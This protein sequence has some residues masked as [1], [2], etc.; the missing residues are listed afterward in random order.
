MRDSWSWRPPGN[1]LCPRRATPSTPQSGWP[2]CPRPPRGCA[3]WARP[4]ASSVMR[5]D[6]RRGAQLIEIAPRWLPIEHLL[7]LARIADSAAEHAL[8]PRQPGRSCTP[9]AIRRVAA[10]AAV[11]YRTMGRGRRC[12]ARGGCPLVR[13]TLADRRDGIYAT[14]AR[15]P[16]AGRNWYINSVGQTMVVLDPPPQFL[17]GSPAWESDRVRSRARSSF[18]GGT[19]AGGSRLPP[20][21]LPSP[22]SRN[23]WRILGSRR[24]MRGNRSF[25]TERYAQTPNCPQTAV[26]WYDA[27]RFCQ[28]LSERENHSPGGMV[29]S[30]HLGGCR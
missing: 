29:L 28:W 15:P 25:S 12:G 5:K 7:E 6:P 22:C 1:V 24:S 21:K 11:V 4:S 30:G 19:L 8:A 20:P 9:R 10:A 13:Q 16:A 18:I 26:R 17:M 27:V 2:G 3:S 23:F 14:T